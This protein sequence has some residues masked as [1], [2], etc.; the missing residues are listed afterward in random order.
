MLATNTTQSTPAT[1]FHNMCFDQNS[2]KDWMNWMYVFVAPGLVSGIPAFLAFIGRAI[3]LLMQWFKFKN[4]QKSRVQKRKQILEFVDNLRYPGVDREA[5]PEPQHVLESD[6]TKVVATASDAAR[7][8]NQCRAVHPSLVA[9]VEDGLG[10]AR[11]ESSVFDL[12]HGRAA[13]LNTRPCLCP[14]ALD[15]LVWIWGCLSVTMG[16]AA[17][18]CREQ[19]LWSPFYVLII[20]AIL[21]L[22]DVLFFVLACM[23]NRAKPGSWKVLSFFYI[24]LVIQHVMLLSLFFIGVKTISFFIVFIPLFLSG[25][26]ILFFCCIFN[27]TKKGVIYII[28]IG[29]PLLTTLSLI[30]LKADLLFNDTPMLPKRKFITWLDTYWPVWCILVVWPVIAWFF[31]RVLRCDACIARLDIRLHGIKMWCTK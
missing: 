18:R 10:L 5:N 21:V 12:G 14:C 15:L 7:D 19:S 6:S 31:D 17:Q 8:L 22:A 28:G 23:Y 16:F 30:C 4:L 2:D 9:A 1:I 27:G 3:S 29:L 25:I 26:V 24:M 11:L 13:R 20:A